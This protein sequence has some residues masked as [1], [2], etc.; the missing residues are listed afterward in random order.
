[1]A[2]FIQPI[3]EQ[4]G[5]GGFLGTVMGYDELLSGLNLVSPISAKLLVNLADD[6]AMTGPA[7]NQ[8]QTITIYSPIT[9]FGL[10]DIDGN[11]GFFI[12]GIIESGRL[13]GEVSNA[14]DINGDGLDDFI[15]GAGSG[16]ANGLYNAGQIYIVFGSSGF[17]A[18]AANN[19]EFDLQGLDG[20]NG[21]SITGLGGLNALGTSL[22]GIGDFNGDGIDDF[23]VGAPGVANQSGDS[24]VI[25][26]TRDGY[27]AEFDLMNL[28]GTNGF[29]LY[30]DAARDGSG[31]AVSNAGDVNG[32]GFA[33]IIVGA[34]GVDGVGE[35]SGE[36]YVVFGAASG[37]FPNLYLN[38]LDGTNGF[39][40]SSRVAGVELGLSVSSAGD[41]NGDGFDDILISAPG[42]EPGENL[43]TGET[44]IIFGSQSGFSSH[45]DLANLSNSEGLTIFGLRGNG[46]DGQFDGNGRSV[47]GV[48]DINGDGLDD[49]LIGAP[50]SG[51]YNGEAYIIFGSATRLG[52]Y[53]V[54]DLDGHNGFQITGTLSVGPIGTGPNAGFSVSGAGDVNGDGYDDFLI[55]APDGT[56]ASSPSG[57]TY[58]IFGSASGHDGRLDLAALNG[59]EGF[60]I[61]GRNIGDQS[62]SS[63]SSA[64]DINGDGFDD[65]LI[66]A[67]SSREAGF[68]GSDGQ[69][70]II[71]GNANF[72]R[73]TTA[74]TDGNDVFSARDTIVVYAGDGDDI[75]DG[76]GGSDYLYGEGGNDDMFGGAANDMLDGGLGDDILNGGTGNDTLI[77]GTGSDILIGAD[78]ADE[79]IGGAG[80][81]YITG[82]AGNDELRGGAGEDIFVI[83]AG[84]GNDVIYD[85]EAGIDWLEFG[86]DVYS[87][88]HLKFYQDGNN[89]IIQSQ[90]GITTLIDF[91]LANINEYDFVFRIWTADTG[92]YS[93]E[94]KSST[95]VSEGIESGQNLGASSEL[96]D[97]DTPI[98]D[99][100]AAALEVREVPSGI[101]GQQFDLDISDYDS[102]AFAYYELF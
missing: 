4:F 95:T 70:Y 84:A 15:I 21:F 65:I 16:F 28:D 41:F 85:F 73:S 77:G 10:G 81:D 5:D 98:I 58:L 59:H 30:G 26:G 47:S 62:G 44:Y 32:D 34:R 80:H 72:G 13:G 75:I 100:L 37:V 71:Y 9:S 33:D 82:C 27:A 8:A 2:Y 83:M 29:V 12:N 6:T 78:G 46:F 53:D 55:G 66:G 40:I 96:Q 86:D 92:A 19:I 61:E 68:G 50:N 3:S 22:S 74:L 67:A 49:V 48:G 90:N 1:M 35:N 88:D 97:F 54:R 101:Y 31:S 25:F 89:V 91:D 63:V 24:Y 36:A 23:I 7:A 45:I 43:P 17:Q 56:L 69:S 18:Q 52:D 39:I 94:G 38:G 99:E 79:L 64:G 11:N 20:S 14:G 42:I 57:D 60:I 87:F 51:T 76:L 102:A 93:G